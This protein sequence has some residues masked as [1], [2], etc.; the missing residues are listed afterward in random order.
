MQLP[1]VSLALIRYKVCS[2]MTLPCF[3]S[4]LFNSMFVILILMG[5]GDELDANMN[6]EERCVS[7]L[8]FLVLC[9]NQ[10]VLDLNRFV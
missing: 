8:T 10:H 3:V 2:Y 5:R 9:S 1:N 7:C 4:L 6:L